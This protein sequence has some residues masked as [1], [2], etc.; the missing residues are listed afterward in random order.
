MRKKREGKDTAL[1]KTEPDT[2]RD[3]VE[4]RGRKWRNFVDLV[5]QEGFQSQGSYNH[6]QAKK[7]PSGLFSTAGD[8]T[9]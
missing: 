4:K 2:R 1:R 8:G 5:Q 6:L 9:T 3:V 7:A